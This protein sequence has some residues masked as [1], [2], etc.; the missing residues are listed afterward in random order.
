MLKIKFNRNLGLTND[1]TLRSFHIQY[2][3]I[4]WLKDGIYISVYV[5]SYN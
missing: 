4:P 5:D 3:T 1:C 2:N